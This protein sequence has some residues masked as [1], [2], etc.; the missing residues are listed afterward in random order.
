MNVVKQNFPRAVIY[1]GGAY[2]FP[3]FKR[4]EIRNFNGR[5]PDNADADDENKSAGAE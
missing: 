5:Q 3:V 2:Y 4:T 1:L